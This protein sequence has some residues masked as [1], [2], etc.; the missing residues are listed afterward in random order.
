MVW[1][2]DNGLYYIL[3]F[4]ENDGILTKVAYFSH[5]KSKVSVLWQYDE[6]GVW[7]YCDGYWIESRNNE[8]CNI[9]YLIYSI[10]C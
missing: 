10:L 7:I 9:Y 4:S 2:F 3:M 8:T 6:H 5:N 1:L